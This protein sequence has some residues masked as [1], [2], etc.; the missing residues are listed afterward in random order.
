MNS[1]WD[2]VKAG[3][4]LLVTKYIGGFKRDGDIVQ[5]RRADEDRTTLVCDYGYPTSSGPFCRLARADGDAFQIIT[6]EQAHSEVY[7][8]CMRA[9]YNGN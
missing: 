7:Q 8:K 1:P 6:E 3:D 9:F 2:K 5:V 4:W